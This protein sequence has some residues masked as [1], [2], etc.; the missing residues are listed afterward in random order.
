MNVAAF[1][2]SRTPAVLA[3]LFCLAVLAAPQLRAEPKSTPGQA[4]RQF[5]QLETLLPTPGVTRS[6]SGA[7]G[8]GY[9]Q[10]RADYRIKA[11]LDEQRHRITA[12]QTITYINRSPDAL[13]YLWLQLDQNIFQDDSIARRTELAAN[14]GSRRDRAELR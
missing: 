11:K 7:P 6:A 8:P 13:T 10:Q 5:A 9:W 14:A 3:A 4:D 12:S 1:R 2:A